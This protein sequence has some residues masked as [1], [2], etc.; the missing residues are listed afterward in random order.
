[1]HADGPLHD[2]PL[3]PSSDEALGLATIDHVDPFHDSINVRP[4]TL[5]PE[6]D[7]RPT[8]TQTTALR[9]D[10]PFKLLS[11]FGRL[12]L[13]TTDHT[14]PFHDSISVRSTPRLLETPTAIHDAGPMHDTPFN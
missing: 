7:E 9:H 6:G 11:R 5:L 4:P 14:D 3:R 12:G 2:T 10:T 8:A 1:M 13:G